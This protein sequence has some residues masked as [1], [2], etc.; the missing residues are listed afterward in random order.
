MNGSSLV[1]KRAPFKSRLLL[2]NGLVMSKLCYLIQVWG[3]TADFL[4]KGLQILHNKSTCIVTKLSWYTP[5]RILMKQCNWLS[6][7]QL[8]QYHTVLS[9]HKIVKTGK[10]SYIYEKLCAEHGYNTRNT[11]IFGD[12]FSGKSALASSSFCYRGLRDYNNLPLDI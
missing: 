6:V 7:N 10:P 2:A 8:I 9:I 12:K 1:A 3:G 5:T 4:I 11:V